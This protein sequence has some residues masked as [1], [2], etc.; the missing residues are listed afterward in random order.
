VAFLIQISLV[1]AQNPPMAKYIILMIADGWGARHIEATNK[2][3]G[4]PPSYQ[5]DPLWTNYYMSTWPYGYGYDPSAY[6]PA[7]HGT[8]AGNFNYVVEHDDVADLPTFNDSAAAASTL[9]TGVK[10]EYG[11]VSVSHDDGFR[12]FTIGEKAKLLNRAVGAVSNVPVSHAT[13]A[14]WIAHND[15][16]NNAYAIADEGF[17]GD[18]NITGSAAP[19]NGYEGGHG[20]TTPT[21]DV[22]IGDGRDGFVNN[23]IRSKLNSDGI[24]EVVD[25]Q[26]DGS[27]TDC[28]QAMQDAAALP[29][30][31]KLAGLFD[32]AYRFADG[33]GLVPLMPTLAESTNAAL[34]V[35]EQDDDGFVLMIEGGAVD[36]GAHGNIMDLMIGEMIDFDNAVQAVI[37]WVNAPNN[38][39]WTN[40]LLIVTGDHECGYLTAGFEVFPDQPLGT[41][42]AATLLKEKMVTGKDG[43]RASWDDI[44]GDNEIDA[45]ETVYWAW[46]SGDH[47]NILIPLYARGAGQEL[48][49]DHA[50]LTDPALGDYVDN[51]DVWT[52]MN[53]VLIEVP[54]LLALTVTAIDSGSATLGATIDSDGGTAVTE[55]GTVWDLAPAP[56]SNQS[57]EGGTD[58]GAFSHNRTGLPEGS[59]IYYR[60]YATNYAGT[61][62]SSDDFF[63][64]EP[65]QVSNIIFSNV[66]TDSMRISWEDNS[67][68]SSEALVLMKEG[69][70]VDSV[71]VDGTQ[72]TASSIFGSGNQLGSGN[73]VVFAETGDQ[74]DVSG[75]TQDT[76]YYVA[77][78]AYSGGAA[79]I[80]YQQDTPAFGSQVTEP[81]LEPETG[82][83][84]PADGETLS[85]ITYSI[86]GTATAGTDPLQKVEVSTDNGVTWEDATGTAIWSYEWTL[87]AEDY[88]SHTIQVRGVDIYSVA[89]GTPAVVNI[90]VDTVTP[91]GV[92]NSSPADSAADE[93]ITTTVTVN[94][95]TEG[96]GVVEYSFEVADDAGFTTG[97]QSSGWQAETSYAPVLEYGK[98]YYWHVKARDGAGNETGYTGT[99]SFTTTAFMEPDTNI[100][101][102]T[103]GETLSGTTYSI[104]VTATEGT[105]PLQKVEVSTDGGAT[106]NDAG[107]T[108]NS[109]T[110][111]PSSGGN[112]ATVKAL[113]DDEALY[114]AYEVTDTQLNASVTAR[115]GSVWGEDGVEWAIDTLTDDGG[116]GDPN[117]PYM[118]PDDYHGIINILNTQYDS[119]GTVSGSPSS[120]WDGSWQS[121]V[122]FNGTINDNGDTDAGYTVEVKIPWTEI[123]YSGP[124]AGGTIVRMGF[125][126]NDKDDAS[127][128][129]SFN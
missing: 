104:S 27:I 101:A 115:D 13:P 103:E 64:T 19:W 93:A 117:A 96:S 18:P 59:K 1:H 95:G 77:V 25:C 3:T 127:R 79:M 120:A 6:W 50:V 98:S 54:T 42:S 36:W 39:D 74:V 80:N 57:P 65:T 52:V 83:T 29:G 11:R 125:L 87:P 17:F 33:S 69:S 15:S 12:L 128:G 24:Y 8:G 34:T 67:G 38:S 94:A 4:V 126:L 75:L 46:N 86:T 129:S 78:Y 92:G 22:L 30:V 84:A 119:Q 111:S 60:G 100:E 61:G 47:S 71:P 72:Y 58:V 9:Y 32:F 26:T 56:A 45:G 62:Y 7:P 89:E 28:G 53:D 118:L 49:D 97:L 123:G 110:L 35:L 88:I 43:R 116:S 105:D 5:T 63:Y 14:A 121:A 16:R 73:Y 113:W 68:N 122:Q 102:P 109:I 106:W 2:Y 31:T 10:T 37:D 51:V 41:V 55:R 23:A 108:A 44:D 90:N 70:P 76:S 99:W 48:F 114:L 112:T 40:T 21:V 91:A 85:G 81:F 82:I 20:A 66:T 124:P 107:G